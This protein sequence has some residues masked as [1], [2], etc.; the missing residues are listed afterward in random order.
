M[1]EKY[2]DSFPYSSLGEKIT[3]KMTEIIISQD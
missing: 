3:G 2:E 1:R